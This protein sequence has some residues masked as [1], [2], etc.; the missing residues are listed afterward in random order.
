MTSK[1][2]TTFTQSIHRIL[3]GG[4]YILKMHNPYNSGIADVW[5]SGNVGDLWVEYKY[6]P[7]IPDRADIKP[8]LLT[9][10]TK[11]ITERH[12]EGRN[13]AVIVG[14]PKGGVL[15]RDEEWL[16]PLTNSVFKDWIVSRQALAGWILSQTGVKAIW[17]SSSPL[18]KSQEP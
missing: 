13:V 3:A 5:Y 1:P 10:Q 14:T 4:P 2:E 11:W 8:D 7:I 9:L 12:R 16:K 17:Q 15:L 6:L 18:P